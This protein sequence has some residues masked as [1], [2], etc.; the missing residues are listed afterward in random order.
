MR[1]TIENL[2]K[3]K[4]KKLTQYIALKKAWEDVRFPTKKDGTLFKIMSKNF[5]N[6]KYYRDDTYSI[7]D[8]NY[9]LKASAVA[10]YNNGT[11]EYISDEIRCSQTL[12]YMKNPVNPDNIRKQ[13]AYVEDQYL[14][15]LEE[16]KTVLIPERIAYYRDRIAT[17]ESELRC[18]D[19][20]AAEVEKTVSALENKGNLFMEIL[21][22]A[23]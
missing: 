8:C 17:L 12:R 20:T 4:K 13:G 22:K 6:A 3:K 15:D 10:E 9:I 21:K 19:D 14:Y 5:E 7:I 23:L 11:S 18:L 1:Y 16:I 2:K